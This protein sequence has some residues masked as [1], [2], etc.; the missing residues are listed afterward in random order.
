MGQA[1]IVEAIGEGL[2]RAKPVW[3]FTRINLELLAL[4]GQQDAYSSTI[5][6][7]LNAKDLIEKDVRIAADALNAVIKQWQQAL[8]DK[9]KTAGPLTPPDPV[10]PGTGEPWEDPDRAQEPVLLTAINAA[11]SAAGTGNLTRNHLLDT[12][13]LRYLRYQSNTHRTGHMD[14]VGRQPAD[15][16]KAVGY[17]AGAVD[18]LLAYGE[19]TP[20]DVVTAWQRDG[21]TRAVLLGADWVDVGIAYLYSRTH[22]AAHLWCVVVAEPGVPP[23]SVGDETKDKDPATEKAVE[24]EGKLNRVTAPKL[25]NLSPDQLGK[26]AQAY[27]IAIAK[28]RAAEREVARIQAEQLARGQ[29]IAV[30]EAVKTAPVPLDVWCIGYDET[31]QPGQVV[32]TIEL[33]GFWKEAGTP[34]TSILYADTANPVTVN[35]IERSWNLTAGGSLG[36][37][38]G[39]LVPAEGMTDAAVF[40]NAALEPGH[41]KWRPRW[42]YGTITEKMSVATVTFPEEPARLFN[43]ESAMSLQRYYTFSG[44][45]FSYPPCHGFV[46]AVGDDVVVLFDGVNRDQPVIIGFRREPRSCGRQGWN[47]F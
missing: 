6:K 28:L 24:A 20:A 44:I 23:P 45:T 41:L 34:R 11:R 5:S 25:D 3:D 13:A 18:E 21:S 43:G 17:G 39:Q 14:E 42:R 1:T 40:V 4:K 15:R 30:L 37:S 32:D 10:D 7:A 47:Q 46:F 29:R 22:Y 35:W 8:I 19:T 33:P 12:A 26:A 16:V 9:M 2:Y 36:E 31:F 27:G 38:T